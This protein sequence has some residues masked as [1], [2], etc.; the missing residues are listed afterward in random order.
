MHG[1]HSL[2]Q[3]LADNGVEVCFVNP[4]TTESHLLDAFEQV[5]TIRPILGLFE[6][7]CTGAADGYARMTGRPAATVM[8]HGAGL[9]YGIPNLHNAKRARSPVVNI[10]GDNT[11][12]HLKFDPP[13]ASDI[14]ALARTVGWV[15]TCRSAADTG[16]TAAAA[17]AA[18]RSYPAQIAT[19]VLPADCAWDEGGVPARVAPPAAR[20]RPAADTVTAVGRVLASKEPTIL[21]LG[22][23]ALTEKGLRL[24]GRIAKATGARVMAN[25]VNPRTQ[26]G[27]GRLIL[28]RLPYQPAAALQ[29]V[30]NARHMILVGA[31]AP[32]SFYAWPGQTRSQLYPEHCQVQVL[33]DEAA[34]S[35]AALEALASEVRAT[36][37]CLPVTRAARRHCRPGN[38]LWRGSG[39]R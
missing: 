21:Y 17:L 38:S 35:I 37:A 3:T 23:E 2:V 11:T 15:R 4:G 1:A 19:I 32:I 34:D 13:L 14:E 18:A 8:H 6:A 22:G 33:A 7:V 39:S 10:V 36:E 9:S 16:A 5:K 25:R 26:R 28:E 29:M 30:G 24:A 27:A 20:A 12:A 31:R